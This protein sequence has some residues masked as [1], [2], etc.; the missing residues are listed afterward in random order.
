MENG[1]RVFRGLLPGGAAPPV[2]GHEAAGH[3][4]AGGPLVIDVSKALDGVKIVNGARVSDGARTTD[5]A[6]TGTTVAHPA[7]ARPRVAILVGGM[8]LGAG[9]TRTA[10]D[11]MPAAVTLAFVATGEGLAATVEA[12][13]AKGHEVLAQLPM[14]SVAAPADAPRGLGPHSLTATESPAALKADLDWLLARFKGYDGVTNLLGA[15]VTETPATMTGVLRAVGA[16][17]LFY[18][19]DGT[20]RRSLAASLAPG[21]GVPAMRA[22][23]VLDATADP[24]TVAANLDALVAL[25]RR[26]GAAIGMASGLPD[27]L[28]AIARYADSLARQGVDLVPVGILVRGTNDVTAAR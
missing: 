19:D 27:H 3:E 2:A 18:V 4:A 13:R 7:V 8:G 28:A 5:A 15:A 1:V 21:L 14:E 26:K 10:I 20:S 24:A 12:A 25:A 23:I 6:R 9:A 16:R 17:G 11:T 22:D